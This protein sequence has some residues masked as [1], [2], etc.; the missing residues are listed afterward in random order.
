MNKI[1][2]EID[3]SQVQAVFSA[4]NVKNQKKTL[5]GGIRKSAQILINRTKAL[6]K[7][8][9]NN[10]TKANR[11]NGKKMV[12]GVKFK[13]DREKLE[14]K[15]HIMGD[16]RLKFFEKGTVERFTKGRKKI[17]NGG[18]RGGRRDY[19]RKGKGHST[20]AI[21]SIGFFKQAKADTEQQVF[22]TLTAN[23]KESIMKAI[24]KGKN[25]V[26]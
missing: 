19:N 8:N 1:K 12:N 4:L 2:V 11:F 22:S 9:L 25:R 21:K 6:I 17:W 5:M 18:F 7:S 13:A 26:V 16:F 10:T 3:D 15:V 20:G 14:G 24:V 23:I